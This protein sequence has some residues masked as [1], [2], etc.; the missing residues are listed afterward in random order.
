MEKETLCDAVKKLDST[1]RFVGLINDKGHLE[2]GGMIEG[3][4]TLEDAKK[5]EMLYMELAL[6]VRMRQEF[7]SELGPVKF[8]MSYRDKVLVM[9]F[10]I[11]KEILLVSAE[12][13][14]N[15]FKFPFEVLKIIEQYRK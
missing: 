7:D 12:K 9:S 11:G 14:M 3:K 8:A 2:A 10:P 15:F 6:R 1:I 13:E 5:D 4:S